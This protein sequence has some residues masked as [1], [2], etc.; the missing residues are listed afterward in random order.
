MLTV[1]V[2]YSCCS[3]HFDSLGWNLGQ[4]GVFTL[5]NGRIGVSGKL[6]V[7]DCVVGRNDESSELSIDAC[8]CIHFTRISL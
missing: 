3:P 6:N 2:G 4:R 7:S 8:T 5:G 1:T